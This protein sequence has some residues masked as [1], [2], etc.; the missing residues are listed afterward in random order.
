MRP[1][2]ALLFVVCITYSLL[3]K[4]G[5]VAYYEYNKAYIAQTLCENR[6]KPQSGCRGKCYLRRQ[7]AK[8]DAGATSEKPLIA[9]LSKFEVAPFVLP[10]SLSLRPITYAE[11]RTDIYYCTPFMPEVTLSIFHPPG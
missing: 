2:L 11:E 10:E 1:A 5:I 7:L 9:Q 8:A 6:D 3:L 4:L